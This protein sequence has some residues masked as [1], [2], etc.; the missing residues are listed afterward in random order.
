MS[1]DRCAR[2]I[3]VTKDLASTGELELCARWDRE[4][5]VSIP[6]GGR[7]FS[8]PA[9]TSRCQ[10]AEPPLIWDP[11][12]PRRLST[13]R[14]MTSEPDKDWPPVDI[15]SRKYS[16]PVRDRPG[17]KLV[18]PEFEHDAIPVCPKF[19]SLA[20]TLS[21]AYKADHGIAFFYM[22]FKI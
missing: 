21:F 17:K 6:G 22:W 13:Y 10:S 7:V 14:C 18:G 2:I 12:E 5:A 19:A 20:K 11:A 3:A 15:S 9:C 8:T 16:Q 1:L 4:R